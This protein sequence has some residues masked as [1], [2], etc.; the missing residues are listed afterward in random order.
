MSSDDYNLSLLLLNTSA[1]F[2][3][4]LF[5]IIIQSNYLNIEIIQ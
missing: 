3:F 2:N 5:Q 1:I 4:S